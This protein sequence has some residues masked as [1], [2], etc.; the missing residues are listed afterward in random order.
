MKAFR[1]IKRH[2]KIFQDVQRYTVWSMF[3]CA[4][5]SFICTSIKVCA[6]MHTTMLMVILAIIAVGGVA[7]A[8]FVIK[9]ARP[10][11][12]RYCSLR[13]LVDRLNQEMVSSINY[14][15]SA[16]I[17]G[18]NPWQHMHKKITY[19]ILSTN[20]ERSLCIICSALPFHFES[21]FYIGGSTRFM[22]MWVVDQLIPEETIKQE[23]PYGSSKILRRSSNKHCW[24]RKH[25]ENRLA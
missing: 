22:E 19:F 3:I 8:G 14:S 25:I 15:I 16:L 17:C 7:N 21:R 4:Y 12:L 1:D 9:L 23:M 18:G 11:W 5:M 2:L 10:R 24:T 13:Q 6:K 20:K